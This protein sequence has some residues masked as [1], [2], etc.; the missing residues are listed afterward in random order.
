MKYGYNYFLD[1]VPS[2]VVKF[3]YAAS[4]AL[5][6]W[7]YTSKQTRRIKKLLSTFK[8]ISVRE[9]DA[10][11]LCEKNLGLDAEYLWIQ[12]CCWNNRIIQK[13]ALRGYTRE[14]MYLYIGWEI[15]RIYVM[16]M[17]VLT[18]RESRRLKYA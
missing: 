1:F 3:S 16:Q 10:V 17:W 15:L 6:G 9:L 13:F 4:F 14:D 7:L 8:G 12:H 18:A 5:D 2:N 11:Q